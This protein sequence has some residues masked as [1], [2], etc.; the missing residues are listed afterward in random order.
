M[1]KGTCL[2]EAGFKLTKFFVSDAELLKTIP[3]S[4]CAQM[5]KDLSL[6]SNSKVL[7]IR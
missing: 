7:G 6:D 1:V 5:V 2:L 3:E 4:D